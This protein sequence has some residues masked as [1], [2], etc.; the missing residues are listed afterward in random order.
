MIN[1]DKLEHINKNIHLGFSSSLSVLNKLTLSNI[2]DKK[3]NVANDTTIQLIYADPI[4]SSLGDIV[5]N[6]VMA[7]PTPREDL[8]ENEFIELF[9]TTSIARK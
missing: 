7:D 6:E 8:P 9:N 1:E 2:A 4:V 5:I 3:L